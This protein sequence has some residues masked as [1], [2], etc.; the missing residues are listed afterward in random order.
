MNWHFLFWKITLISIAFLVHG[1]LL[2]GFKVFHSM[3]FW[4]FWLL[5]KVCGY[6]YI[7]VCEFTFSHAP[8]NIGL[9]FVFLTSWLCCAVKFLFW[10]WIFW[11]S[12]CLWC[13]DVCFSLWVRTVSAVIL[14]DNSIPFDFNSAPIIP[15]ILGFGF[16][17]IP[18]TCGKYHSCY[19]FSL[20][21]ACLCYCHHSALCILSFVPLLIFVW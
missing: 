18:Q 15:I 8:S 2:S 3:L 10:S 6:S 20:L 1:Y 21:Y 14:L 4:L 5:I 12:V 7:S 17:N 9:Y 16:L 11:S 13:L 19:F